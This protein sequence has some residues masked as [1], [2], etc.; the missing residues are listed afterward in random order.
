MGNFAGPM[1][2]QKARYARSSVE[3]AFLLSTLIASREEVAVFVIGLVR[4]IEQVF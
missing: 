1:G 2:N 3:R 4:L